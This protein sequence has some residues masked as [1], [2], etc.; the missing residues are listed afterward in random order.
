MGKVYLLRAI[1]RSSTSGLPTDISTLNMPTFNRAVV[2]K[3]LDE[4]DLKLLRRGHGN[5]EL[6]RDSRRQGLLSLLNY[7]LSTT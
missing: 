3:D 2:A 5:I 1:V 4:A 6:V 7:I